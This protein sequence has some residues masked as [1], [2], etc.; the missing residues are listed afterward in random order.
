MQKFLLN[1]LTTITKENLPSIHNLYFEQEYWAQ[2]YHNGFKGLFRDI[3]EIKRF[4]NSL[5]FNF[6]LLCG[7]ET[8]EVNPI[9]FIAIEA[10]RIIAPKY[11]DCIKNN[12]SLFTDLNVYNNFRGEKDK[13]KEFLEN[14]FDEIPEEIRDKIKQ[15]S[16]TLFPQVGSLLGIGY[17]Y[18]GYQPDWSNNLMIC[19]PN[20]FK[21]YFSLIPGGDFEEV[22]Q[23]EIENLLE[24]TNNENKLTEVFQNY[25]DSKKIR[26]VIE[27]LQDY[28]FDIK[29]IPL[30]RNKPLILALVNISD[31]LPT[32]GSGFIEY[33]TSFELV[34]LIYLLLKRNQDKSEN[35]EIIK[36]AIKM[37]IGL[38]GI[39]D[40]VRRE[41]PSSEKSKAKEIVININEI[42]NLHCLS[43]KKIKEFAESGKLL[44]ND[45]FVEILYVWKTWGQKNEIKQYLDRLIKN[46]EYFSKTCDLFFNKNVVSLTHDQFA[47][48]VFDKNLNA[49]LD[50]FDQQ[51][52][53][54]MLMRIKKNKKDFYIPNFKLV[55]KIID[56]L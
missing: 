14:L 20:H 27:R 42:E 35:T 41:T 53:K 38:F 46:D 6:S 37:S 45:K 17:S 30:N 50:F 54:K 5:M 55:E 36:E 40:F 52:V 26:K 51:E 49:L 21:T 25:K 32:E 11:Y 9:D 33:G 4:L 47:K 34:R 13:R 29:R 23:Y 10:I 15:L 1:N 43:I 19:S 28:T 2:I 12:Q 7:E 48:E 22:S 16:M 44:D 3:R 56:S 18:S 39:I 8:M 24:I 31:N